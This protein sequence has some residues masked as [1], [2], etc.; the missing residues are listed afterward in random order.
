MSNPTFPICSV[1]SSITLTTRHVGILRGAGSTVVRAPAFYIGIV[2]AINE[3][4]VGA[5]LID[6]IIYR[7]LDDML[8]LK[9]IDWEDRLVTGP[10]K[11][12]APRM[13]GKPSNQRPGPKTHDVVGTYYEPAYGYLNITEFAKTVWEIHPSDLLKALKLLKPDSAKPQFIGLM[14][15]II[16]RGVVLTHFDG[17]MY[18]VANIEVATRSGGKE[19]ETTI[20]ILRGSYTAVIVEGQGVGIFD[21]FWEGDHGRQAVEHN[22]EA[23]A[24]VW[25][26][27]VV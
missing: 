27:K 6:P 7:I 18:N 22:V 21:N 24:E 23:E 15:N 5:R 16:S 17:P 9:P 25:F 10:M 8:G 14:S 4:E 20:P 13:V 1:S 3:V 26:A 2:L 12:N 19:K 11:R